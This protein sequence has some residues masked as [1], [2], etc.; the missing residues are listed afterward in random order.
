MSCVWQFAVA[1]CG[2]VLGRRFLVHL[3][4]PLTHGVWCV[5]AGGLVLLVWVWS[6]SGLGIDAGGLDWLV[7]CFR[8]PV[9]GVLVGWLGCFCFGVVWLCCFSW[10]VCCDWCGYELS[11]VA[12]GFRRVLDFGTLGLGFYGWELMGLRCRVCFAYGVLVWWG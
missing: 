7:L 6:D 4:M 11:L 9:L 3:Q 12:L 2:L 10:M 8:L 5:F 1:W